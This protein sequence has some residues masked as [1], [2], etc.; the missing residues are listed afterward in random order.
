MSELSDWNKNHQNCSTL[1]RT[2]DQR[3]HLRNKLK[4]CD[5]NSSSSVYAPHRHDDHIMK[6]NHLELYKYCINVLTTMLENLR[7]QNE[8]TSLRQELAIKCRGNNKIDNETFY[9]RNRVKQLTTRAQIRS[10]AWK[11]R[12]LKK[13]IAKLRKLNDSIKHIYEKKLQRIIRVLK[14]YKENLFFLKIYFLSKITPSTRGHFYFFL[15]YLLLFIIHYYILLF[16]IIYFI[17]IFLIELYE[18]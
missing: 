16:I 13:T 5:F 18:K 14:I 3:N 1:S 4:L 8:Q 7:L 6:G 17:I 9:L 2:S 10:L 12:I 15:K 11:V